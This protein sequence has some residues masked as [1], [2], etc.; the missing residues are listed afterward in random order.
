MLSEELRRRKKEREQGKEE[1]RER[2]TEIDER[3]RRQEETGAD[4]ITNA[5]NHVDVGV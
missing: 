5:K 3:D 1:S 4:Q 2:K